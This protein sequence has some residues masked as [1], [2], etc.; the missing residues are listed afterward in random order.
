MAGFKYESDNP[1]VVIPLTVALYVLIWAVVLVLISIPLTL[2]LVSLP[3]VAVGTVIA[4]AYYCG[5]EWVTGLFKRKN[6]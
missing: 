1:W 6:K 2:I 3:F 4:A 5:V